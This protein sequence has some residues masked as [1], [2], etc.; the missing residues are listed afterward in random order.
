MLGLLLV[1]E[2]TYIH[3][4]VGFRSCEVSPSTFQPLALSV[5]ADLNAASDL[6]LSLGSCSNSFQ[7]LMLE[8]QVQIFSDKF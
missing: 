8:S 7:V 4:L 1:S 5:V 2:G 3:K 6:R